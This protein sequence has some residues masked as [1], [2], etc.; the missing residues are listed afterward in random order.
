M[1]AFN[2]YYVTLSVVNC[3]VEILVHCHGDGSICLTVEFLIQSQSN[4]GGLLAR[5]T[6]IR[7]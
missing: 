6:D 3:V 2:G 4:C 5:R 7:R 1:F